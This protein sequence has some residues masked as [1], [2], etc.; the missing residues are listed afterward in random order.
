MLVNRGLTDDEMLAIC[1]QT[2]TLLLSI[3]ADKQI[4][5]T[6]IRIQMLLT[7][8]RTQV[9]E[10]QL[11]EDFRDAI[12]E[13]QNNH[14]NLPQSDNQFIAGLVQSQYMRE[15]HAVYR[16]RNDEFANWIDDYLHYIGLVGPVLGRALLSVTNVRYMLTVAMLIKTGC[17]FANTGDWPTPP[18]GEVWQDN[19]WQPDS[20]TVWQPVS[21]TVIRAWLLTSHLLGRSYCPELSVSEILDPK[22]FDTWKWNAGEAI[23]RCLTRLIRTIAATSTIQTNGNTAIGLAITGL[24]D[25]SNQNCE[26]WNPDWN[27]I[28]IAQETRDLI[29]RCILATQQHARK[30]SGSSD[31]EERR[32]GELLMKANIKHVIYAGMMRYRNGLPEDTSADNLFLRLVKSCSPFHITDYHKKSINIRTIENSIKTNLIAYLGESARDTRSKC[33]GRERLERW[34]Q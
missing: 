27:R 6:Y 23:N 15:W 4:A 19:R 31:P 28:T 11:L 32:I 29:K 2:I 24:N 18:V 7:P 30:L 22:T 1:K 34:L 14:P 8:G 16:L 9:R 5:P 20:M 10:P 33:T 12:Q 17:A 13:T 3:P 25:Y 26:H 21:S